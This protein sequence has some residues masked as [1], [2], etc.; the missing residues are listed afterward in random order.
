MEYTKKSK[1]LNTASNRE[2]AKLEAMSESGDK[3]LIS[4][5]ANRANKNIKAGDGHKFDMVAKPTPGR[6]VRYN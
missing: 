3:E 4:A 2:K 1:P 5:Y 6:K